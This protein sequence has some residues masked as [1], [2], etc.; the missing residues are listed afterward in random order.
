M[1]ER[2][3]LAVIGDP[4]VAVPQGGNDANLEPDPGRKLHG[5]SVELLDA[6]IAQVN[7]AGV[8]AVLV[9]GDL[10][11]DGES[12]NHEVARGLL[13]KL[14]TPYYIVIGNHDHLRQR[15]PGVSYPDTKY[16]DRDETVSFYAKQGFP[17]GNP[18]Y[19]VSLPGTVDLLVLNSSRTLAEL[20]AAGEELAKQDSGWLATAQLSWLDLELNS[21]RLAGRF[22][23]VALHHSIT[24]H[25]PAEQH[26]HILSGFFKSWQLQ[27]A[28]QLRE[29]LSKYSV[30]LVL[31]GHLHAQSVNQVDGMTNLVTA[32]SVSYPHA[33]RLL[34]FAPD[35]I[36]IES[37][38]LT[39]IPSCPILQEKSRQWMADGMGML[40]EEK[41]ASIP[42]LNG[43]AR[44]LGEFVTQTGWWSKLCDG[45]LAGFKVDPALVPKSNPVAGM[46]FKQI[47][48]TL[49][50]FGTWKAARPNP[51]TLEIPIP[52]NK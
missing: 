7:Q 2:L 27:N 1:A 19:R 37:R 29:V 8:D 36:Q 15:K 30:P 10:T 26:G 28:V 31:S 20:D 33:W 34:T 42:L 32:A 3:K 12:F 14:A 46:I 11:R 48:A 9:L 44:E 35:S 16:F 45:T 21:V 41:A 25:S 22:P 18:N 38:P 40:I 49:E 17:Q 50:E 23:L 47:I 4:H 6:T 24:D 5:L 43:F 51:N 52:I 13:A 39:A